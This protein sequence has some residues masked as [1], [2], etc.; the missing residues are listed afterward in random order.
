M[1]IDLE[2][3]DE[4]EVDMAFRIE[5][6]QPNRVKRRCPLPGCESRPP[7]A[8]LAKH[9]HNYHKIKSCEERRKWLKRARQNVRFSFTNIV[10]AC[11]SGLSTMKVYSYLFSCLRLLIH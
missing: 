7:F 1:I 3:S 4:S 5:K 11:S 9:I 2:K 10:L 6:R 8:R